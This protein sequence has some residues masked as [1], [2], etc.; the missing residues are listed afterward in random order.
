MSDPEEPADPPATLRHDFE[1]SIGY[2]V[3]TAAHAIETAMNAQLAGS[4]IT[5]R[6][7]QILGM[8]AAHGEL[9]QAELAEKMRV[10]PSSVV[11][12]LDRMGREGWVERVADPA[13]RRRNRVRAAAKAGPVWEEIRARLS[14]ARQRAAAG[15]SGED[16]T[17]TD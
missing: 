7:C 16:V 17:R 1:E 15:L 5:F 13:D 3:F 12:L 2:W 9:S 10:E 6:Q 14:P 4:G 8:L 11:R